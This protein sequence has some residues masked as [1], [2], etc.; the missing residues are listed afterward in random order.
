MNQKSASKI[1]KISSKASVGAANALLG[2]CVLAQGTAFAST[3]GDDIAFLKGHTDL[4]VLTDKAGQAKVAVSP[5][6]QGRVLTSS[7]AGDAGRSFGWIN[8]ELISAGKILPHINVFGGEDRFWMGPEGGQFSIFFAKGV[9]FD[10]EHWFTPAPLDTEPFQLVRQADDH[11]DF[12]RAFALTNYSGTEFQV[13]VD[14]TVKLLQPEG[15][16]R[17]LGVRAVKDVKLVG[18]ESV[19]RLKN[20]GRQAWTRDTGLLSVW[21]LG[22]FN[23]TPDTTIVIPIKAGSPD[24]L[25]AAVTSDYFGPVP[26]ERLVVKESTI[27]FKGDGKFRSKIGINPRRCRGILGSYDSAQHVLTLVQFT[28]NPEAT[29]YV[30]SMW[31]IQDQPFAGDVANSYN[32]GP[33]A[34]GAKPM[35][36]FYEM[37]SSSPAAALAPGRT[38]EHVHR[39][40]PPERRGK[41]F[42]PDRPR[43][44]WRQPARDYDGPFEPAVGEP[45]A[46]RRCDGHGAS[47]ESRRAWSMS[48]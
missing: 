38:L 4:V 15:A 43:H 6:W 28:F 46:V 24:K 8:R 21:I 27:F 1:A 40:Y 3:F 12:H 25:G 10:L 22:M 13:A 23:P 39:T 30:N 36:P 33:P 26:P 47:V 42:G 16:W 48:S 14:R 9:P 45:E 35:G 20:S 2:A 5:Q 31:K 32:D 7:A 18:F 41:G 34:P 29:S 44:S 11:A 37:E 19:N 17:Y